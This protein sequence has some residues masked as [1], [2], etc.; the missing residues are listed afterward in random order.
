MICETCHGQTNLIPVCTTCGGTGVAHC[1]DGNHADPFI[2]IEPYPY[3]VTYSE[4]ERG[5]KAAGR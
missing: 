2:L 1:C 5:L 3:V 4:I